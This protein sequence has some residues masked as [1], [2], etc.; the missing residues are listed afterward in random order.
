[1]SIQVS[2][3]LRA[4]L[5]PG[6]QLTPPLCAS[7]IGFKALDDTDPQSFL[8]NATVNEAL[9]P[10]FGSEVSGIQLHLLNDQER[11]QLALW[12]AQRGVVVRDTLAGIEN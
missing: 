1:M 4:P 6:L 3:D 7:S 8:R 5:P 2:D 12:V 11:S 10:D 9:T